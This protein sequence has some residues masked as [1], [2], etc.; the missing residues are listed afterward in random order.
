MGLRAEDGRGIQSDEIASIEIAVVVPGFAHVGL[1]P[2]GIAGGHHEGDFKVQVCAVGCDSLAG[3]GRSAHP[4]EGLAG[5]NRGADSN[6]GRNGGQMGVQREDLE[7]I[8]LM[9]DDHIVAVVGKPGAGVHIGD[10]AGER[11]QGI[12]GGLAASVP[13]HGVN[14]QSLVQLAA[15]RSDAPELAAGPRLAGRADK[16]PLSPTVWIED[17]AVG[18]G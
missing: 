2:S 6:P 8:D 18:C 10:L 5:L 7:P 14:V 11:A 17:R 9:P 12:I 1:V 15:A 16:I 3:I 4:T 13:L